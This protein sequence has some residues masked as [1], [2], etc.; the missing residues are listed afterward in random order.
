VAAPVPVTV[1]DGVAERLPAADGSFDAAVVCLVLCSLVVPRAATA[2]LARVLRPAGQVRFFEHVRAQ[3]PVPARLQRLLDATVWPR[4]AGGC[5]T[6]RDPLAAFEQAGF[7]L[8]RVSRVRFPD[9]T[10]PCPPPR[11][12]TCWVWR[13]S[14][15]RGA[16]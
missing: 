3:H 15:P 13:S 7:A 14:P 11:P 8:G 16:A 12:H 2:E 1:V 9:L 4:I 6:A 10:G 5:H